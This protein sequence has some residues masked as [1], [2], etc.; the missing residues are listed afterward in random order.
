MD[1]AGKLEPGRDTDYTLCDLGFPSFLVKAGHLGMMLE[2]RRLPN[3]TLLS[4]SIAAIITWTTK[5]ESRAC[6]CFSVM[7]ALELKQLVAH[8]GCIDN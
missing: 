1:K 3:T 5:A 6:F 8:L 7:L 2:D 4:A